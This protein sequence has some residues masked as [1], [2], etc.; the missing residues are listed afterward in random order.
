VKITNVEANRYRVPVTVPSLGRQTNSSLMLVK[1]ET[2]EGITGYGVPGGEH[3]RAKYAVQEFINRDV[4]PLLIGRNPLE[5]ERRWRELW[6]VF[7]VRCQTGVWS[8]GVSA[9]DIA[10]WD[11][12]GKYLK[13]PVHRLLGGNSDEV[14]A[15]VTF[16]FADYDRKQL[17]EAA[18]KLVADGHDKLKMVVGWYERDTG[19][20]TW[21]LNEDIERVRAVREAVGDDVSLMVDGNCRN[22]YERSLKIAKSIEPFDITW[23][24]E[25]LYANDTILLSQ[26]RAHTTIPIS[27]GGS[28]GHKWAHRNLIVNKAVDIVQPNIGG[29]GGF[30]EALKIAH[31]A[32]AFNLQVNA[33]GPHGMHLIAGVTN[34]WQVE[35]HYVNWKTYEALFENVPRP[36]KGRIRVSEQP[37]IGLEPKDKALSEFVEN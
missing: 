27:A 2:D 22:S 21:S 37:G 13:Q 1:V 20:Y 9:I 33:A 4:A 28:E 34:G 31:L 5:T 19:K 24:E 25:P 11:I 35:Y 7:N 23:F 36:E 30:T 3:I 18:S 29:V 16:G 8:S 26:L 15:Y 10:L 32:Q 17:V 6:Q 12:K 14:L